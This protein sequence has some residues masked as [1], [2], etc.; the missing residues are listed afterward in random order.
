MI[1][2]DPGEGAPTPKWILAL[3][4]KGLN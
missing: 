1:P 3:I 4:G 2:Q